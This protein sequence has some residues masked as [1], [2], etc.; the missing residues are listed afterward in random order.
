MQP[1]DAAQYNIEPPLLQRLTCIQLASS[2]L[3]IRARKDELR[4]TI[5]PPSPICPLPVNQD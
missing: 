3:S 5:M 1:W 2:M 4:S